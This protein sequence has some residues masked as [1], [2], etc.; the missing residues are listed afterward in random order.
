M[1]CSIYDFDDTLF[2]TN[3]KIHILNK[4]GNIIKSYTSSEYRDLYDEIKKDLHNGYDIDFSDF[5]KEDI[6]EFTE[7]EY[8]I[9]DLMKK[10]IDGC[11]IFILTARGIKPEYLQSFIFN[12]TG[13]KIP[14]INVISVSYEPLFNEIYKNV[15]RHEIYNKIKLSNR[16]TSVKKV[17]GLINILLKGY[18]IIDI[19]DDDRRN[20]TEMN[21]NMKYIK[22][23]FPNTI[24]NIHH[25]SN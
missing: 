14:L 23:F 9:K 7:I 21:K 24:I 19:Y 1:Y 18:N 25:I 12:T 13:I 20:I 16:N 10:Y 22:E 5:H 8:M 2:I 11:D 4:N 6:N 17:Y 3:S 15:I